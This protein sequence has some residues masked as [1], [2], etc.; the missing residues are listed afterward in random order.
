[1][2]SRAKDRSTQRAL[3][4]ATAADFLDPEKGCAP[5]RLSA[6]SG[7]SHPVQEVKALGLESE[8][9]EKIRT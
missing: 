1:M 6:S 2:I 7:P 4:S 8:D 3:L 9:E 5:K